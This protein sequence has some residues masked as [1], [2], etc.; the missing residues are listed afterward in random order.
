M[1]GRA[2]ERMSGGKDRKKSIAKI[3]NCGLVVVY[4]RWFVSIFLWR[5]F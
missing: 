4:F 3:L 1:S 5:K 2:E